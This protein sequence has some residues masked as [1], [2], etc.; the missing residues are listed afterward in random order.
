MEYKSFA[1]TVIKYDCVVTKLEISYIHAD[2][3]CWSALVNQG[4]DNILVTHNINRSSHGEQLFDVFSS[5]K[6]LTDI[7]PYDVYDVIELMIKRTPTETKEEE[8]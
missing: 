8:T 1:E 3:R 6:I 4:S 5:T 7:E 2:P